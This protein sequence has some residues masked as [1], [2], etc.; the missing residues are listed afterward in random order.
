MEILY[1]EPPVVF[2]I[3]CAVG[4]GMMVEAVEGNNG[5]N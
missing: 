1:I 2:E 5:S 4:T 3:E